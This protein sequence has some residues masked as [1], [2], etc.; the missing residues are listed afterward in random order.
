[1]LPPMLYNDYVAGIVIQALS[2]S[3][4]DEFKIDHPFVYTIIKA[5]SNEE[6]GVR[7]VT[8]IFFGDIV[9]PIANVE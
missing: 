7:E 6:T 5:S 3:Y 2:I 1:M 8:S 9:D 4:E